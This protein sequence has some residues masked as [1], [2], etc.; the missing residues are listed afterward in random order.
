MNKL[1]FEYQ[2][3]K[4]YTV[5]SKSEPKDQIK[6]HIVFF[7]PLRRQYRINLVQKGCIYILTCHGYQNVKIHQ[8]NN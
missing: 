2:N 7:S 5:D 6:T 8:L 4:Q 1:Q 3:Q